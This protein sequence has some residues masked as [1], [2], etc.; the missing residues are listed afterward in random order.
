MSASSVEVMASSDVDY[1]EGDK[2]TMAGGALHDVDLA[3][4]PDPEGTPFFRIQAENIAS[5]SQIFGDTG[6]YELSGSTS[7]VAGVLTIAGQEIAMEE[8][9]GPNTLI[10]NQRGIRVTLNQTTALPSDENPW[11]Y[12]SAISVGFDLV[13]VP[14]GVVGGSIVF[15]F[16]H[17]E[18]ASV[19]EPGT[20]AF[21][22]AGLLIFVLW[23]KR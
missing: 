19:P 10:Y 18:V 13:Q 14:G 12:V 4:F 3:L 20:L 23:R 16:S 7:I 2:L 6:H 9:P 15:A 11:M 5:S 17:E 1:E 22:G 21:L 8:N